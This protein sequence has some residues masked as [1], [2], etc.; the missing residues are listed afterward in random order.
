MPTGL[1]P[2]TALS[3]GRMSMLR[4]GPLTCARPSSTVT[5]MRAAGRVDIGEGDAPAQRDERAQRE[6]EQEQ[7][8][9]GRLQSLPRRSVTHLPAIAVVPVMRMAV[10][11]ATAAGR[12]DDAAAERDGEDR[13]GEE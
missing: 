10:I 1:P 3:P 5:A 4:R 11:A 8:L 12:V 2:S 13:Q 7:V 9:H 6:T